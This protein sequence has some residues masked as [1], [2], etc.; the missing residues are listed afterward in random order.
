[1]PL[2]PDVPTSVALAQLLE[3]AP[4][5]GVSLGWLMDHL[6][7]R[8]FGL[9]LLILSILG[10][11]PGVA[12]VIGL[13]IAIPAIELM[14]GR[15]TPALPQFLTKRSIATDKFA[16]AVNRMIPFFRY[17]EVIVR[18]RFPLPFRVTNELVGL[19]VFLLAITLFAPFPFNIIPTL[20]IMLIAFSYLQEDG[21]FLCLSFVAAIA[22]LCFTNVVALAA[23]RA[24]GF[25][26]KLWL[27]I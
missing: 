1:M 16:A 5:D 17:M 11:A 4:K 13:V 7:K 2:Q 3:Q 25:L 8:A 21:V 12:T 14:L 19:L 20:V 6:Q 23:L 9:L 26:H 27:H 18:P 10:L 15:K 24:T 22:S